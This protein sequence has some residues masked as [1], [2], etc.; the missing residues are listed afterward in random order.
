MIDIR[1]KTDDLRIAVISFVVSLILIRFWI[2]VVTMTILK[3]SN[4]LNRINN[5]QIG[6]HHWQL[7]VAIILVAFVLGK[8]FLKFSSLKNPALG[9]GFALFFDQYTYILSS[10]G[11]RLPFSYRSQ[12]DNL[13]IGALVILSILFWCYSGKNSK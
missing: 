12:A 9:F 6:F 8:W 11:V 3:N 2:E 1:L 13:I 10:L 5:N 7:G 4:L